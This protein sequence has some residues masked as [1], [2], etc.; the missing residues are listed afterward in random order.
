M[1]TAPFCKLFWSGFFVKY[2]LTF[3]ALGFLHKRSMKNMWVF[4]K[5]GVPQNGWFIMENL[6]NGWFCRIP[7]FGN[8]HVD[9][10]GLFVFDIFILNELRHQR[11]MPVVLMNDL[12]IRWFVIQDHGR[13]KRRT[14]FECCTSHPEKGFSTFSTAIFLYINVMFKGDIHRFHL[15]VRKRMS[16]KLAFLWHVSGIE[17]WGRMEDG[18]STKPQISG[19]KTWSLFCHQGGEK[20]LVIGILPFW[21]SLWTNQ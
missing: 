1:L 10:G 18:I 14:P 7:I 19:E 9:F 11:W 20:P 12:M 2:L 21:E 17:S 8:T 16:S 3:G 6:L 15:M 5:I 4:P 13:T